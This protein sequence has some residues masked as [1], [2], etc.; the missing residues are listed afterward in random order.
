MRD[1]DR[2]TWPPH[3]SDLVLYAGIGVT[4]YAIVAQHWGIISAGVVLMLAGL[5][6]PRMR[7][8]FAL[9]GQKLQFRGELVDPS[10]DEST[11]QRDQQ[12]APPGRLLPP[13]P[14]PESPPPEE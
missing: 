11:R 13:A 10:D 8:P 1:L 2:F 12:T 14:P 3:K 5:L 7:G 4:V 6:L 9:G